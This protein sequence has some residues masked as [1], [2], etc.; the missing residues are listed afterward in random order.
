ML[1]EFAIRKYSDSVSHI[2]S[3]V[4]DSS[5]DN[6]SKVVVILLT[7]LMYVR[8][9]MLEDCD[10]SIVQHLRQ[11]SRILLE[12]SQCVPVPGHSDTGIELK[13]SP[14]TDMDH[15]TQVFAHLDR[16]CLMLG[17][18]EPLFQLMPDKS[19][20][21]DGRIS[22]LPFGSLAEAR[23]YLDILTNA[24]HIAKAD[25]VRLAQ[26]ELEIEIDVSA[27]DPDWYYCLV[28]AKSRTV[29]IAWNDELCMRMKD[30]ER[31]IHGW[32]SAVAY[33]PFA[34]SAT[35]RHM[36]LL[37]QMRYFMVIPI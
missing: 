33:M 26:N 35:S 25:L 2:Q 1:Y 19:I 6:N 31:Q 37:L 27:M 21:E 36:W 5:R 28:Q 22:P 4:K 15:I 3:I 24:V 14:G 17:E 29:D 11:G 30:L 34:L 32:S 12:N 7:C 16:D 18:T 8:L 23:L 9:E 13:I 20:T 10:H